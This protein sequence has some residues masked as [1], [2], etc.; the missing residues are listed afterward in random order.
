M[1]ISRNGNVE[2]VFEYDSDWSDLADDEEPDSNDE[3]FAGNDYPEEGEGTYMYAYPYVH[4]RLSVQI[5]Y[6]HVFYLLLYLLFILFILYL[7]L[8]KWIFNVIVVTIISV[9]MK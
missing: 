9:W 7:L 6:H 8:T 2:L 5:I 3:R 1:Q 4:V